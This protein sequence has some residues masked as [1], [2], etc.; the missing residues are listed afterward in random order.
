MA[1][2]L[3]KLSVFDSPVPSAKGMSFGIVVAEWN[4][5]ITIP[6]LE[7]A[8]KLLKEQGCEEGDIIIKKVPG[9]YELTLAS[10]FMCEYTDVDAV[11]ALGCVIQGETRHFDFICQGVTHGINHVALEYNTP[12]AFGVLTVDNLEQAKDRAGGKLGN[13]GEEAAATAIKMAVIK[14]EMEESEQ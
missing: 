12:I 6:L 14:N 3:K 11:I 9:T 7:G 8:V 2:N 4:S 5:Q 13:K 1:S 10:H